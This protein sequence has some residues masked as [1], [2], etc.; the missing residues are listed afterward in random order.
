MN[1]DELGNMLDEIDAIRDSPPSTVS[2]PSPDTEREIKHLLAHIRESK[3]RF[4]YSDEN[5][6]GT[7]FY[8]QLY[9]KYKA[10]N[11]AV[12]SA[13]D[14]IDK[15]ATKTIAGQPYQVVVGPDKRV[16]L[17]DWLSEEL[18]KAPSQPAEQQHPKPQ[19][20]SPQRKQGNEYGFAPLLAHA[21]ARSLRQNISHHVPMHVGQA[22]SAG[23][24]T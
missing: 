11:K 5:K 18:V 12:G 7:R 8:L 6:G 2:A 21:G 4:V 15:V 3:H 22:D 17:N 19:Q 23:P 14:F 9:A 10:Y 20:T 24:G 16:A 13:E 1:L